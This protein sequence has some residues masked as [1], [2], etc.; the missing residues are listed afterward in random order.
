[1]LL[2]RSRPYS[3]LGNWDWQNWFYTPGETLIMG[4]VR[5]GCQSSVAQP[6]PLQSASR[7]SGIPVVDPD[8]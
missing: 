7:G 5:E 8:M 4:L 2:R 3:T 6:R 1:M